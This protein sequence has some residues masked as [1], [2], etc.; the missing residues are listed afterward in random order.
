MGERRLRIA[1]A[2][3]LLVLLAGVFVY[4]LYSHRP[5]EG[6]PLEVAFLD[7]GKGDCV[8][9]SFQE[10]TV[11]IDAGYDETSEKVLSYLS[12]KGID[13]VDD[14]IV[15]HFD[16]DHAGGVP[17][18]LSNVVVDRVLSPDY[19]GAKKTYDAYLE[20]VEGWDGTE[21]RVSGDL[22]FEVGKAMFEIFPSRVVYDPEEKNDN[23]M[24]L[25]VRLTNGTETFLFMG[26]A[27]EEELDHYLSVHK[28]RA[29]VIK[30][31][32]HGKKEDN[33]DDLLDTVMPQKAVITDSA[34]DPAQEKLLKLLRERGIEYHTTASE[35]DIIIHSG[36]KER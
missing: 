12:E 9:L 8:V 32:H 27:E 17:D 4:S 13:E 29:D 18:I 23:D 35:G 3:A 24:S 11:M 30:M 34:G 15:T 7:V 31:P 1:I 2:S 28:D 25:V 5:P 10:H 14:L 26:D 19:E 22:T 6:E 20:A 21:E 16:K 33:S 36:P